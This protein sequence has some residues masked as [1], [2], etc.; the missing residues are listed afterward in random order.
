MLILFCDL[1]NG[2]AIIDCCSFAYFYTDVF[3][4]YIKYSYVVRDAANYSD[5]TSCS[6]LITL[7]KC[8]TLV[9]N[10]FA[11]KGYLVIFLCCTVLSTTHMNK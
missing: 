4:L 11:Q 5:N 9:N 1:L 3:A 7:G 8:P 10:T 2:I 6:L